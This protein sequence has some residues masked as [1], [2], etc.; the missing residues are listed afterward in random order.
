MYYLRILLTKTSFCFLSNVDRDWPSR[1][2]DENVWCTIIINSFKC[3]CCFIETKKK[4][5]IA[6]VVRLWQFCKIIFN[7]SFVCV[8]L[9]F[10][11]VVK[12]KKQGKPSRRSKRSKG[13]RWPR[14]CIIVRVYLMIPQMTIR[15]VIIFGNLFRCAEWVCETNSVSR[16]EIFEIQYSFC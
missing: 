16:C 14:W 9:L 6:V 7:L 8:A 4:K 11:Q 12:W 1:I 3:N 13:T 5:C 2:D 15:Q 10:H